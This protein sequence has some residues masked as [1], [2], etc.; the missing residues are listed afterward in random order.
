MLN[1]GVPLFIVDAPED[2]GITPC[3][4]YVYKNPAEIPE[5]YYQRLGLEKPEDL[6]A[7]SD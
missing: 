3:K 7:I 4:I 1:T 5:A 6:I 2:V